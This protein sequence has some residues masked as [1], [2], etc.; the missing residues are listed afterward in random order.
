MRL[1][2][3]TTTYHVTFAYPSVQ[4][5]GRRTVLCTIEENGTCTIGW[6]RCSP[7]DPFVKVTGRKIALA[8]AFVAAG[9][10]RAQRTVLW[11]DYH[12]RRCA[13]PAC[14]KGG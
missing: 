5:T 9:L 12:H 8:R 6:A 1:T 4:D 11:Q 2:D 13:A 7:H 10:S 14:Q 3:G